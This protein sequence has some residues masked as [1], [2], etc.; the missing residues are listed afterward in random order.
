VVARLVLDGMLEREHDGGFVSGPEAHP[1]FFAGPAPIQAGAIARLSLE[2]LRYAAELGTTTVRALADSLYRYNTLPASPQWRRRLPDAKAV[3]RWL[4]AAGTSRGRSAWTTFLSAKEHGPAW[5][6]WERSGGTLPSAGNATYK[7]YVAAPLADLGEARNAVLDLAS[8]RGAP[9][10]FKLGSDLATLLRPDRLVVYFATLDQLQEG[11]R[12]LTSK[13]GGMAGQGVPFT[14]ELGA[15]LLLSWGADP[16][17]RAEPPGPLRQSSW[18][19]WITARLAT[20]LASALAAG[21]PVPA[22]HYALDRVSLDGVDPR[23]WTPPAWFR[24]ANDT[25]ADH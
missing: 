10:A 2:G 16:G 5:E 19:R 17:D 14:A 23:H 8:T 11:A 22:W 24:N 4:G 7:L 3:S 15:G 18:R 20:A 6:V 1:L 12:R 21:A 9:F 13:L 25:Y